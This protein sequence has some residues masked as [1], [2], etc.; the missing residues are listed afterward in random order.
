[1]LIIGEKIHILNPEVFHAVE[2][3]AIEPIV[4]LATAQVQ[5]GAHALDINLGPGRIAGSMLP[6]IIEAIQDNTD[7]TVCFP[8]GI[9]SFIEASKACR[10]P[11]IINAVSAEPEELARA[12]SAAKCFDAEL[13]V[14]LTR[15]GLLPV[16]VDQWCLLAEEVIETAE[17]AEFPLDKLYL[18]PVLRSHF[19]P[20]APVSGT[21]VME[22]GPVCEA[23]KLMKQLRT[24]GIKTIA[25]LS[26]ISQ[27][28]PYGSRSTLHCAVLNLLSATGLDAVILNPLDRNLMESV[29][30]NSVDDE[31]GMISTVH[32]S[33]KASETISAKA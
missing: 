2:N 11:P 21:S 6:E 7:A 18:D 4:N 20:C 19:D 33:E 13:V 27:H 10:R 1:M 22:T 14:L 12:M 32:L 3:R 29:F 30:Q 5:A 28:L 16:T 17:K 26:N 24:E 23:L 8:A 31:A 25:G 15:R 9:A